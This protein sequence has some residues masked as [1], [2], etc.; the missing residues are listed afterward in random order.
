M[1]RPPSAPSRRS[2]LTPFYVILGV[3]AL[4][5]LGILLFQALGKEPGATEPVAVA[6]DP[7]A[8]QRVQGISKGRADAPVVIYEFADYQCPHCAEFSA[9]VEPLI[10]ERLVKTGLA[11]YVVYEFPLGGSFQNGFYA[12]RAGR[13]ANEQERF[14]DF[15]SRLYSGQSLW[16]GE[17]DPTQAFLKLAGDTG[18]DVGRFEECLRSDR[19]AREISESRALGE[20]LGVQGTPTLIVN[21]KRLP[22]VPSIQELERVVRQESGAEAGVAA[23]AAPA[24][25]E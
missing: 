11:R 9:F 24:G 16:S 10:E 17:T 20:S 5:G 21:G 6:L 18:L 19:Y 4:A 23:E 7:T 25:T 15:H 3:V 14:W 12:A 2:T 1:A 8:L 13:C 22:G